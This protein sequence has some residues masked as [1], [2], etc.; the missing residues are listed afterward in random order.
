MIL[1]RQLALN[2]W[3]VIFPAILFAVTVLAGLLVRRVV[4]SAVRKWAAR[5]SSHLDVFIVEGLNG[6]VLLWAIILG[7]HVATQNSELPERYLRHFPRAL[8]VMWLVS[9]MIAASKLAGNIVRF[10][11]G[12]VTGAQSVTSLTQKLAQVAVVAVGIVW[13]LKVAFDFSLT[14]VLTTLGVGGL[15]VALALQDT[16]SNLFAGFYTS[17]SGHVRIG[18]YIKL[19][20]NE[21]GFVVDI[22]WRSTTIRTL[23]NNLI[24]IPNSKLGQ[25]TFTNYTLPEPRMSISVTVNV[26]MDMD[27]DRVERLLLEE[28]SAAAKEI[29]GLLAEPAPSV[30]FLPGVTEWSIGLQLNLQVK[31]F[32]RQYDV[33]SGVR[34]R[35]FKRFVAEGISMPYPTRTVF[36]EQTK[37]EQTKLE[38]TK[39]EQNGSP[40]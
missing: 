2:P 4:F 5:T 31:E 8:E 14:P 9:L 39:L 29:P 10:Y 6:A 12:R 33:Q 22:A 7:L 24:V 20:T 17:V 25:A 38:Q 11:G 27:I 36:L 32:V 30:Q 21:E 26:G 16:L 23:A 15:A 19:N 35:I 40:R 3:L 18:D 28:A 1:L 34:K 13:I 37:L